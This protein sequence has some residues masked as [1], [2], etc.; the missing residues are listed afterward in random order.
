MTDKMNERPKMDRHKDLGNPDFWGTVAVVE[1]AEMVKVLTRCFE[2]AASAQRK[3]EGL[4]M[5]DT[6]SFAILVAMAAMWVEDS[7]E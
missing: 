7:G 6:R 4:V 5:I 3:A 2:L 1:S